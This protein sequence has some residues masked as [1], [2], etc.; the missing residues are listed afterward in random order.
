LDQITF[1]R[2]APAPLPIAGDL[3]RRSHFRAT[4]AAFLAS[5]VLLAFATEVRTSRLQALVFSRIA[6][7]LEYVAGPGPSPALR[8]PAE[9]PYDVRLGYAHLPAYLARLEE[10][11][12]AIAAQNRFSPLLL[13]LTDWGLPPPYPEKTRA[14]LRVEDRRG[15]SIF[16]ALRPDR[17]FEDFA[18]IPPLIVETLLFIENRELLEPRERHRN[19]AIEWD[20]LARAAGAQLFSFAGLLG[21]PGGGSTLAT[22][23]EKYRHSPGG[24]TTSAR[25]KLRQMVSA[26][27]R[28]YRDGADTSAAR[29]RIV[30]DYLNTVPLSGA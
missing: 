7:D 26:S 22:Q 2:T 30:L 28:A 10:R 15:R 17:V 1:P 3:V 4:V 25:E 9:G 27:L 5:L 23:M 12:Y 8:I 19:P 16:S 21:R 13:R 18:S 24:R 11:G 14:G 6:R 20:R 29:R